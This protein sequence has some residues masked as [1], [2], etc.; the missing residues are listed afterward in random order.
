MLKRNNVYLFVHFTALTSTSTL[1]PLPSATF[2]LPFFRQFHQRQIFIIKTAILA[3]TSKRILDAFTMRKCTTKWWMNAIGILCLISSLHYDA[4]YV[5]GYT[6]KM[7]VKRENSSMFDAH[8]ELYSWMY[9][10]QH[11]HHHKQQQIQLNTYCGK[12]KIEEM[13]EWFL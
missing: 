2:S 5:T 1:Q 4:V 7:I 11:Q 6:M 8:W 10:A 3:F 12:M 9:N 13:N